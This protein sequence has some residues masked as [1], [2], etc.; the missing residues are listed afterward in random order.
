MHL[1]GDGI[2]RFV[3]ALH[4]CS[5]LTRRTFPSSVIQIKNSETKAF[6]M[7]KIF[8]HDISF[9]SLKPDWA[10]PH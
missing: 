6:H 5:G 3:V 9:A 2:T 10:F 1:I 7:Q 4:V 8:L